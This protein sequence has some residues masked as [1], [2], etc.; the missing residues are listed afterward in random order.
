MHKPSP[1]II[2]LTLV[3]MAG[4]TTAKQ[5]F[6]NPIPSFEQKSVKDLFSTAI[7]QSMVV[8]VEGR[9]TTEC[10]AGCWFYLD[11]GTGSV[12]VTLPDFIIPQIA[13]SRVRVYGF[14]WNDTI[15]GERVEVI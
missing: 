2:L 15:T 1:A 13:G 7:P 8:M 9:I 6:G 14:F 12:Y 10:P 5:S 3:L 4:C 11:D